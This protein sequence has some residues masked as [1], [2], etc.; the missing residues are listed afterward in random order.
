MAKLWHVPFHRDDGRD[1][2]CDTAPR[3]SPYSRGPGTT[4]VWV[5]AEPFHAVLRADGHGRCGYMAR[6]H[7]FWWQDV[8]GPRRYCMGPEQLALLLASAEWQGVGLV[9]GRWGFSRKSGVFSLTFLPA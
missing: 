3:P 8:M 7:A 6:R 4:L 1:V 2:M 9:D 5:P